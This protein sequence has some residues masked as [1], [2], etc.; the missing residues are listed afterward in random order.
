M[1]LEW[2]PRD[3]EPK[4]HALHTDIHWGVDETAPSVVFEKRPLM[5]PGGDVVEGL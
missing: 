3:D 1:A 4:D 2:M 5:N